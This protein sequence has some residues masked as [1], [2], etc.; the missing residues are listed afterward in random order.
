MNTPESRVTRHEEENSAGNE[1][2]DPALDVLNHQ[3]TQSW[4]ACEDLATN[5]QEDHEFL[6]A[7]DNTF[8]DNELDLCASDLDTS[9]D[10]SDSSQGRI[11]CVLV[12]LFFSNPTGAPGWSWGK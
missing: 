5:G 2:V 10:L 9:S 4:T 8:S 1:V 11:Y 12:L 7:E 3:T 6:D